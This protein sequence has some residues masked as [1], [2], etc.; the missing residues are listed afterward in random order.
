MSEYLS[1]LI[2]LCDEST[3][4]ISIKAI[5]VLLKFLKISFCKNHVVAIV[6]KLL[7][8]FEMVND[9]FISNL[10]MYFDSI[11]FYFKMI[12]SLHLDHSTL[13]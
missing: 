12:S 11:N 2:S 10:N 13:F 5:V 8:E 4:I 9:C 3:H 1:M 6:V 7:N